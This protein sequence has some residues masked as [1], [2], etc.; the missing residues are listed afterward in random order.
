MMAK[1]SARAVI[2]DS[3]SS[4]DR[5]KVI[6]LCI[7]FCYHTRKLLIKVLVLFHVSRLGQFREFNVQERCVFGD[8]HAVQNTI[9]QS[10]IVNSNCRCSYSMFV[11]NV[12]FPQ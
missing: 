6:V 8:P 9:C 1:Q 11:R 2:R 3:L 10:N 5:V 4:M 7:Q 12:Y